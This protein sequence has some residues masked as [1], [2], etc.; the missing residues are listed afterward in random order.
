VKEARPA[1]TRSLLLSVLILGSSAF[2]A[3][4]Y[5]HPDEGRWLSRDP[6][7]ER[8]GAHLYGFVSNDPINGV[9]YIGLLKIWYD[10]T[11]KE[12]CRTQRWWPF[13]TTKYI[14]G[15]GGSV[16]FNENRYWEVW[17]YDEGHLP[18]S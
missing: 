11:G 12:I 2:Q 8:G 9:D 6:I 17:E 14:Q 7:G 1:N 15:P 10:S 13:S 4:A 5:Y 16:S 18:G 3:L